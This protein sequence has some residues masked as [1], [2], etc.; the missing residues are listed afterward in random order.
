[1][2]EALP[3][4]DVNDNPLG[5]WKDD[6]LEGAPWPYLLQFIEGRARIRDLAIE[7]PSPEEGQR[8]TSGWNGG[9][10]WS[11][12]VAGAILLTGR[13]PVD[14]DVRRVRIFGGPDPESDVGSALRAGVH[15]QGLLHNPDDGGGY[16]VHPVRGRCRISES[17]LEGMLSGTPLWEVADARVTVSGNRYLSMVGMDVLDATRSRIVVHENTWDV[18][19]IGF[20]AVLNI[21][22]EPSE[23]NTFLVFRNQG[24]IGTLVSFASGIFFWDPGDPTEETTGSTV[25]LSRNRLTMGV[26]DNPA[27]SGIEAWGA[28]QLW[29]SRN[30]VRGWS[31]AG[32]VVDDTTGC[33]VFGNA[34]GDLDT[35]EGP[36]LHLGAGT[37]ACLAVVGPDDVVRD[38]GTDNQIIRR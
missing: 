12:E 33:R 17:E 13:D 7:V 24:S 8:P 18:E 20:E 31:G 35:G 6:P 2:I 16:P 29:M 4:L 15:F 11:D 32:L 22:G 36:D 19:A 34:L 5:Y 21:D 9:W 26:Q 37:S 25:A 38:D 28:G 3:H 30:Q 1:V 10:F 27:F 23:E 14:F